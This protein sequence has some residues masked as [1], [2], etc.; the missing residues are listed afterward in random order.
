MKQVLQNFNS[1]DLAVYDVP[2]PQLR[3]DGVLVRSHYSLISAGTEGGTVRLARMNLLQKA[4][5]RPDLV[6]KVLGVARRDGLMTAYGAVASNLDAPLPLGYSLAGEVVEVGTGVDDLRVGDR[7][8]CFGQS[9]A[10]HAEFNFVPRNLCARVP[11][12]VDSRHAAFCMLGAI[13][14]QGVR[15]AEIELG[16]TAVVIGLGLL[17]QI[18]VQLLRAAGCRVAGIDIDPAKLDLA[19]ESGA[20][21]ALL[22]S[23]ANLEEKL[24]AFTNGLGADATIITAATADPDPVDLAGRISRSRG[25]VVAVGR[26]PYELPRDTYLFKE[27]EFVTTLAFGPGVGDR[28]YEEKGRDYPA[29]HVRWTGNRNVQAFLDLLHAR[30]LELEPLVTHTFP[31]DEAT[32]AFDLLS[33][34]ASEPN[35]G[36]LLS[37]GEPRPAA[38]TPVAL[39]HAVRRRRSGS[40]VGVGVIGAG[41]H[42]VS[43]IFDA[44]A[45]SGADMRGIATAS[46]AKARWYGDK[47]GFAYAAGSPED[48][49]DD[50]SVEAVLILS[51][52]DSHGPLAAAA[53]EAGKAVFVEKPLCLLPSQ[54]EQIRAA[55]GASGAAVMVGYNRRF[56][57]L[58][59]A[60]RDAFAARSQP[61]TA[62]YR[63]NVGVR[64][65]EH[66]LH[67]ADVGGGLIL[68]EA[69][70]FLDFLH[71]VVGHTPRRVFA[72][73]V[74]SPTRDIIDSD[75]VLIT[76]AYPDGSTG[77]VAYISTGDPA[78]GREHVEIHGDNST[79]LLDDWRQLS[80]SRGGRQRTVRHRLK[81]DK[82]FQ[83][84]IRTFLQCVGRGEPLPQAPAEVFAGM[85][86][87][88]AALESLRT[89]QPVDVDAT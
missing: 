85:D 55:Q 63:A 16:A 68:G 13:A 81:Q 15:R 42:A 87:A 54:L 50:D 53:L 23:E 62:L 56:A 5:A 7:V 4:Q 37:Y 61:L 64:P 69:V 71:F 77:N 88:F 30:R 52:H 3:A 36:I 44:L 65:A 73:A 89:G 45:A 66:W 80:L 24:A 57:P 72:Q 75:T 9:V 48:L 17:G 74:A 21:L 59:T 67:D 76:L 2:P 86:A 82:G 18:T 28:D 40:A 51:R 31:V 6:K 79:G 49:F 33:P 26:V 47:Y 1:G 38:R 78:G 58:G 14:L 46:G 19:R 20:G 22:R 60:L 39:Q 84:E 8:A 29:A 35:V 70:H 34:G 41:S 12:G 11:E 25:R 32:Q 43:F 10:T 83:G 27:I